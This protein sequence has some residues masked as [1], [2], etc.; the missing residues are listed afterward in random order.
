MNHF[1]N[2]IDGNT[3]SRVQLIHPYPLE[4]RVPLD[5]TVFQPQYIPQAAALFVTKFQKLRQSI[6]VLPPDMEDPRL[7]SARLSALLDTC[8]GVAAFD[9]GQLVGYMGWYQI[10]AFRDTDRRAAYCPEWA[11]A[12]DA[13][14]AP[15]IYRALYRAAAAQWSS[16]ACQVHAISLLANDPEI[17]K[18]WFWQGFGL[19]V[20]DA[21][22][23][24]QPLDIP[25]LPGVAV[26]KAVP[27]DIA[28]L[29]AIEAEHR[30]HYT[31][32]PIFMA[33]QA[34]DDAQKFTGLLTDPANSVW[35]AVQDAQ[36]RGFMRFETASFGAAD[37]VSSASTAA[38]TGAYV[39]PQ[40]RGLGIEIGRA[41]V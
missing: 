31:Q 34:A 21:V 26:R 38:I 8:P 39:L 18:T 32:S 11:H 33:S 28:A 17:E 5:I 29:C 15:R 25:P 40:A 22:R 36:I 41:H 4:Q 19:T 2:G 13:G 14:S 12:T 3:P 1:H 16:N 9:Q 30:R 6:P 20:V 27:A 10:D 23:P 37:I 24:M 7:V 35:I